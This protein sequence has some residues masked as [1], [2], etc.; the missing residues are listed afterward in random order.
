MPGS[1]RATPTGSHGS[2]V[3]IS[4][5]E[6]PDTQTAGP[7]EV[8]EWFNG[9]PVPDPITFIVGEDW[10]DK[11]NLYPRQST[12]IKIIFLRDDLFTDFDRQVI[13][14][15][16]QR[17]RDT[18]PDADANKFS[19]R[20]KGL[21]PDLFER[22]AYLK[23]RGYKWFPEL[24]IAIGRRGSKGYLSALCM[25]YVL[26]NY[27]AKGNPQEYYGIDPN[28]PLACAVFAGKKEQAKE[29]LWGDLYGVIT[30]APCYTQYI[31]EA[32]VESLTVYAP[33]DFV[34]M[35][36][37][38]QRGISSGKDAASFRI[39]PRESTP[40]APR[41][42]AGCIL[43]FDEAAHVRNA[44]VTREFGVVYSAARPSLD[45]FGT[46]GFIV[47]PSS[48]WEMIGKFYEL[49]ELSLQREP[50][51]EDGE[52]VPSY[53]DK[54]MIQIESWAIYEDWERAHLLPLFPA[55]FAG[56]LGEYEAGVLPVLRPLK[57]AIQAYDERAAR[58]EKAN[59]DTFAV[60]KRCIDLSVNVLMA[61]LTWKP[62]GD[63]E[64]GD[65]VIGIDEH[66]PGPGK[67]RRLRTA[68]VTAT[69]RTHQKAYR[70]T[71]EDGSDIICSGEHRWFSASKGA[72]DSCRWRSL[73]R[74]PGV[75]GPKQSLRVGDKIRH[76][77][78][79][80][81]PDTTWKAGYLAG[82][83]D[84]EGNVLSRKNLE[85][86]RTEFNITLA[87]NPGL[88]LDTAL[89][90]LREMGFHPKD[91]NGTRKCRKYKITG[92]DECLRLLGQIR[93]CRL[94]QNA[95]PYLWENRALGHRNGRAGFKTITAIEEL[96]GREL[97]D[98]TTTTHTFIADG[99]ISH[100]SDWATAMDA[101]LNSA[102]IDKMFAPWH[103]RDPSWGRP[104]L[105][106]QARG[107]LSVTYTCHGDPSSV[108][109][110]FGLVVAHAEPEAQDPD[111]PH[112]PRLEHAVIDLVHFWDPAD[113]PGHI[114][115][116]DEIRDW[117][118][119]N[120]ASKFLPDELTF[121][122]FNSIASVQ[123]LQK[124]VRGARLPK[125]I[126][127]YERTA[128][129]ALNWA[130]WETFKAAVNM[131]FVHCPPHGELKDE[132][133]FVQKP[134]L[135][136]KVIP[137]TSGPV[138]TKDIADCAVIVTARLLGEQ[139]KAY[140]AKDLKNQMPHMAQPGGQNALDRFSPD[141]GNPYSAA[142]GGSP[143]GQGALARGMRPGMGARPGRSPGMPG[144]RR[145]RS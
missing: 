131:E 21:Q 107:P 90:Y 82:L 16:Q 66:P 133:R 89:Q 102:M 45:Q 18:N 142:L 112:A 62:A 104:E 93:P 30:T 11:P 123:A 73:Y 14:E 135:Q 10:L 143:G 24:I 92:L 31:S 55:G 15:W 75:P 94:F 1:W 126:V 105:A 25:S 2:Y 144:L 128:T 78:E 41:G 7:L 124:R 130:S 95:V 3:A 68:T 35:R 88:V 117:I 86:G 49:W 22:I 65:Q 36:K 20:T 129:A 80:W 84:G 46:D 108:N 110:R 56:D 58:E 125:N 63:V 64:P 72:G 91:T 134:L 13:A 145:H 43:G 70:L 67:E 97:V 40:L 37:L 121:D 76:I 141:Y 132:L 79:P 100:N 29:N 98:L 87:Q 5:W 106:M 85:R 127:V 48:T 47:L 28:K 113:F 6:A 54:F 32:Q 109:C 101:Y 9:P 8:L 42:P 53:P 120:V 59:P 26:W 139:M 122:Q 17:F 38:A 34:R 74:P 57:G 119:D 103:G 23:K 118:F 69:A 140:L 12:L 96:P 44:G 99:L 33:Y 114:I 111:N 61:D 116:Y 4:R 71:F 51:G 115:D 136:Q 27:L 50:D 60:E 137:A 77:V 81:E 19:P 138:Q 39:I 83:Y 52:Y